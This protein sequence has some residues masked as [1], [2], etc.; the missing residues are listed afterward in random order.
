[1]Q[2]G[3]DVYYDVKVSQVT[4]LTL[5]FFHRHGIG[6]VAL[7]DLPPDLQKRF[8]YDPTK[9]MADAVRRQKE[10]DARKL[11]GTVAGTGANGPAATH[12]QEILRHFGETPKIFAQVNMRPRF[13]VLGIGTKDQT[14]HP[15]CAIFSLLSVY[16]FQRA[17]TTGLA[18]VFSEEYMIW[19]IMKVLSKNELAVPKDASANLDLGFTLPQAAEALRGYGTAFAEEVPYHFSISDPHVY[20][21]PTEV[22]DLA[23]KRSP[24][25]G[26]FISGKD[27]KE[28]VANVIQV[29]NA[30]VPVALTLNW[31][32][33]KEFG[34]NVMLDAQPADGKSQHVV[35][36]VG[37]Q[38]KSG[39]LDDLQ[40]LFKNSYGVTW[41]DHGYGLLNYNY[42]VAN[43]QN[44]LFLD[45]E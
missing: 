22:I 5:I 24:S 9:A 20:A 18:P 15:S 1:M 14:P 33:Q 17:P 45:V 32:E 43:F 41:G 42:L 37:Y 11:S 16:A 28:K 7:A 4:P 6:S 39:K 30:G 38:T 34:D 29:I 19:A 12:S 10:D 27:G 44:A 2:V 31:P 26:F 25:D 36:L 40:F 8:G 35:V 13:D 3:K 21:P 23:R